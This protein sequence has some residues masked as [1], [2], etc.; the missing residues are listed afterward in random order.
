MTKITTLD[1]APFY[2]NTIGVDHLFDRIMGQFESVQQAGNYPPHDIV[3]TGDNT[4]EI[5]LAVAGFAQG[6]IDV[7]FQDNILTVTGEKHRAEDDKEEFLHRGISAR[8]FVRTFP[9][10]EYIEVRNAL[11]RDG[12]LTIQLERVLPEEARP[13]TIAITYQN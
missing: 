3:R 10:V 2:R 6:E 11:A 5:R 12:I 13:K 4:Y 1:L 9:L 7:T 8:K